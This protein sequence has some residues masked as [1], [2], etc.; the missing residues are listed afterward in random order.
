MR[1]MVLFAEA[2]GPRRSEDEGKR[3]DRAV[4]RLGRDN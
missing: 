3:T 1:L 2:D 4:T